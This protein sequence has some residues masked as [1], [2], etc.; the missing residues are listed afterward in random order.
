MDEPI[1]GGGDVSPMYATQ[2]PQASQQAKGA[3]DPTLGEQTSDTI[4]QSPQV[5]LTKKQYVSDAGS[6][7]LHPFDPSA[8]AAS[9]KA[10]QEFQDAVAAAKKGNIKNFING[11]PPQLK[12]LMQSQSSNPKVQALLGQ[13]DAQTR[14]TVLASLGLKATPQLQPLNM[15]DVK[16]L[17]KPGPINPSASAGAKNAQHLSNT[18]QATQHSIKIVTAQAA[19]THG[20]KSTEAFLQAISNAINNLQQFIGTIQQSMNNKGQWGH[21]IT[22]LADWNWIAAKQ[23]QQMQS[24][25]NGSG[26]G[27]GGLLN[28]L[29]P[30]GNVIGGVVNAVGSLFDGLPFIGSLFKGVFG[31]ISAV[32]GGLDT[33][34]SANVPI[35]SNLL[36]AVAS[37]TDGIPFVGKLAQEMAKKPMLSTLAI[38]AALPMMLLGPAGM[39]L[40]STFLM[41][42][43]TLGVAGSGSSS[44]K[45]SSSQKDD[46]N[47]GLFAEIKEKSK[48]VFSANI[49]VVG[50]LIKQVTGMVSGIPILGQMGALVGD[51]QGLALIAGVALGACCLALGP[52]GLVLGSQVAVMVFGGGMIMEGKGSQIPIIGDLFKMGSSSAASKPVAEAVDEGPRPAYIAGHMVADTRV[53]AA[54][55]GNLAQ[56]FTSANQG[57]VKLIAAITQL[58]ALLT[59]LK[60]QVSG[61]GAISSGDIPTDQLLAIVSNLNPAGLASKGGAV[62]QFGQLC[63]AAQEQGKQG[64]SVGMVND[65]MAAVSKLGS[66]PADLAEIAQYL[67]QNLGM[68]PQSNAMSSTF[69]QQAA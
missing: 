3:A 62:G 29:G 35:I 46:D 6:P 51:N 8:A 21:D 2:G 30:A 33:L 11:L 39:L 63:Q 31:G 36:N 27:I 56:N 5:T 57:T 34:M 13:L 7:Q 12:E 61:G 17:P 26:S 24:S 4:A 38:A 50:D 69:I 9:D 48:S 68:A 18:I 52:A 54:T 45:S 60:A 14:T 44:D 10:I 16:K 40:A 15:S 1:G 55:V 41:G 25:G 65:L 19:V 59:R 28:S 67:Q 53:G 20:A 64:D 49:P 42:L 23:Q 47:K 22:S 32:T 58:I 37:M 43:A 66:N